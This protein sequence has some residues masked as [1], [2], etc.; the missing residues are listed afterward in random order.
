[1]TGFALSDRLAAVYVLRSVGGRGHWLSSCWAW[2]LSY[3]PS[4]VSLDSGAKEDAAHVTGLAI[5]L[6]GL[7]AS[8][9]ADD[10]VDLFEQGRRLLELRDEDAY[11]A[12]DAVGGALDV[13]LGLGRLVLGVALLALLGSARLPVLVA[14]DVADG[15]GGGTWD[16]G[17]TSACAR[18]ATWR[19]RT[20]RLPSCS[21][22]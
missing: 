13:A 18:A 21:W 11:L 3:S 10:I 4:S 22:R 12:L 9:G 8:H 2:P 1:M 19:V 16:G 5:E 14:D 15:L 6:L 7:V 17:P 20:D